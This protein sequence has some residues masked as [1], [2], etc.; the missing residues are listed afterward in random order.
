MGARKTLIGCPVCTNDADQ[1]TDSMADQKAKIFGY[2]SLINKKSL[3]ASLPNV[4]EIAPAYIKGFRR[5][6]NYP[7]LVGW[8]S[9]NLDLAGI[10]FCAINV[11]TVDDDSQKVNGVIF[12]IQRN[13]LA[14]LRRRELDYELVETEAFDFQSGKEIGT[15][16][17][18]VSDKCDGTYKFDEPA[19]ER[20]LQVCLDG[21]KELGAVFYQEFL[22]TTYIKGTALG[23]MSELVKVTKR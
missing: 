19:Q 16:S 9:H 15:C 10:P 22:A 3:Q 6:F 2:G 23:H 17:V 11:S 8:K 1:V 5:E 4:Q 13:D 12:E 21:A 7:E 20:Y 18:F 14:A